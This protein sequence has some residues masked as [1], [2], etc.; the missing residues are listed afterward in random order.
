MPPIFST[1]PRSPDF[2]R[3][4]CSSQ[5][6]YRLICAANEPASFHSFVMVSI[7]CMASPDR[8]LRWFPLHGVVASA[9]FRGVEE[10]AK[11]LDI[12]LRRDARDDHANDEEAQTAEQGVHE[13]EDRAACNQRDKEQPPLRAQDGQ[14]A[15]HRFINFLA[16]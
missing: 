11:D 9:K 15:V 4:Q 8:D 10:N 13:R 3:K 1:A 7:L 14:R 16:S 5:K 2:V 6:P 12:V